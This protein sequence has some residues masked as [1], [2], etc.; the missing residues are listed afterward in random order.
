MNKWWRIRCL[1][2]Y[3]I[4]EIHHQILENSPSTLLRDSLDYPCLFWI[5]ISS[6]RK[7]L[8]QIFPVTLETHH[9]H[10]HLAC[11]AIGH[12]GKPCKV[13]E[14][15]FGIVFMVSPPPKQRKY[16]LMSVPRS[17]LGIEILPLAKEL[18]ICC[19]AACN[20]IFTDPSKTYAELGIVVI[21]FLLAPLSDKN[22]A[23]SHCQWNSI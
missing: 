9:V 18:Q 1:S 10:V 5:W 19:A 4:W 12:G 20:V 17:V 6:H 21:K 14:A 15:R 13:M 22:G 2:V 11:L 23:R 3:K 8:I 16:I 7:E